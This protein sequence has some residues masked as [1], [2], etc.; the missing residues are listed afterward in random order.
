MALRVLSENEYVTISYDYSNEWLYADW[1]KD[2]NLH[3]VQTGCERMLECLRQ[4]QCHKVLND[5]RRVESMW[6]DASEW[7]GKV[8]LPAMA[9]AGLQYFAWVY[10]P[11]LYSRLS[12]DLTLQHAPEV[13]PI[14]FTFDNIDT[15]S[16]WLQQM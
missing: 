1:Q 3:S 13:G 15:A 10:S 6:S 4:E 8:W 5:N 9:E 16:A 7:V 14:A 12:T 11:N 2:Q